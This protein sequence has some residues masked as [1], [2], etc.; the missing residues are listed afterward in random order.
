MPGL[1]GRYELDDTVNL[2]RNSQV[3]LHFGD[4]EFLS[5]ALG[6]G[7]ASDLGRPVAML[8]FA[9]EHAFVGEFNPR[10]SK[11][12]NLVIHL[13]NLFVLVLLTRT[14][15]KVLL[16]EQVVAKEN[17]EIL[18]RFAPLI[19]LVW[20][21]LPANVSS[22]VYVIQRMNLLAVLFSLLA[23]WLYF[24]QRESS[25]EKLL[26]A[27]ILAVAVVFLLLGIL[28]KENAILALLFV[29]G[30]E[31]LVRYRQ[32]SKKYRKVFLAG[33]PIA[34]MVALAGIS[35]FVNAELAGLY[36]TRPFDWVTRLLL[37]PLA[38]VWYC[39][40]SFLPLAVTPRFF[41]DFL[42]TS[43]Y[44]SVPLDAWLAVL[45]VS[46]LI[47]GVIWAMVW[48]A[49]LLIYFSLGWFFL[50]HL[51]ESSFWPLELGFLHRNY[52]PSVGLVWGGAFLV[53]MLLL[54]LPKKKTALLL[55]LSLYGVA[56][57]TATAL[58]SMRWGNTYTFL[59]S[60]AEMTP[61]SARA[62]YTLGNWLFDNDPADIF[63]EE[64]F[65]QF[66][67]VL[68]HSPNSYSGYY[69]YIVA[70][71]R[72]GDRLNEV[73]LD[74]MEQLLADR[75]LAAG[76]YLFLDILSES[77]PSM[78]YFDCSQLDRLIRAVLS[79]PSISQDGITG[80]EMILAKNS[81]YSGDYEGA[82]AIAQRILGNE[83][84]HPQAHL[85][86]LDV[87]YQTGSCEALLEARR[88]IEQQEIVQAIEREVQP[89][90]ER[91]PDCGLAASEQ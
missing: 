28:S 16:R 53:V 6:S 60:E 56:L 85:L 80:Y 15:F 29:V 5:R 44:L 25:I 4:P 31:A 13:A 14:V 24:W 63:C 10:I 19:A 9:V 27:L 45:F 76:S 78:V 82:I 57:S 88:V 48:R 37:Q 91:Y 20:A 72:C 17:F 2:T 83:P 26:K 18:Y 34:L 33:T 8:T 74:D 36:A 41:M 75:P 84:D 1:N 77:C 11:M 52:L 43:H 49:S 67:K 61:V 55:S 50:F 73:I 66:D 62:A 87:M 58:E 65:E 30:F 64:M 7:I 42:E 47:I 51:I 89:L 54:K 39:A 12:I 70:S 32:Y 69:G 81:F 68:E 3:Q 22:V 23:L 21:I 46:I 79:N 40:G 71:E 38:L 90:V 59:S 86:M 35:W